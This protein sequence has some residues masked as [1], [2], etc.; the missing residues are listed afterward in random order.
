MLV[1]PCALGST[2]FSERN[3]GNMRNKFGIEEVYVVFPLL[4]SFCLFCENHNSVVKTKSTKCKKWG[5]D[6]KK[7]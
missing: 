2:K 1:V 3:R 4:F 6:K 7:V 5:T